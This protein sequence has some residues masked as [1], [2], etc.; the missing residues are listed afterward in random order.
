M[1]F[2]DY[3][4][5]F[6]GT[7][8]DTYPRMCAAF[9]TALARQGVDRPSEEV[10]A[11]IKR[12]M[13]AAV[14]AFSSQY[15]LDAGRLMADYH[16]IE[17]AMPPE[18]IRPFDGA[19][20]FMRAVAERG[21]RHFLYTH[22]D[23][24]ALQTLARWNLDRWFTGGVTAA[25]GFPAKPAPDALNHLVAAHAIAPGRAVMMGDRDIDLEAAKNAGIAGCLFDPE[26]FY[27]AYP[28]PLRCESYKALWALMEL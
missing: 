22:R 12:S 21:G 19:A 23:E 14:K 26:H 16:D 18:T 10:M 4:W 17:R 1:R 20:D 27:D 8:F 9:R 15:A 24:S 13:G 3:I 5:D 11:A 28:A 6:D 7:L 2:T 25:D